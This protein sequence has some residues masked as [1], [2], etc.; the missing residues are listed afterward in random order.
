MCTLD[1]LSGHM[2]FSTVIPRQEMSP[3]V[4]ASHRTTLT[5]TR[6]CKLFPT[7]ITT[8]STENVI[9]LDFTPDLCCNSIA[10]TVT[11]ASGGAKPPPCPPR[12]KI[13]AVTPSQWV[14]QPFRRVPFTTMVTAG[15]GVKVKS[16]KEP[17]YR[18][19]ATLPEEDQAMNLLELSEHKKLLQFHISS[20][21]A[22]RAVASHCNERIGRK[23]GEIL[24]PKQLLHCLK[25]RGMHFTLRA[26]YIDLFNTLHLEPEVRNRLITSGEFIFP[27][28]ACDRSIPLFLPPSEWPASHTSGHHRQ[29][30]S[31]VTTPVEADNALV[32]Q[33]TVGHNMR[34][35]V[36]CGAS[37]GEL[38]RLRFSVKE[39]KQMVF[40]NLEKLLSIK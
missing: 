17:T 31:A 4:S 33:A 34:S 14:R 38:C 3:E 36:P 25:L 20:L 29:R 23:M 15:G 27:L 11:P 37:S 16:Y 26:A 1:L 5:V 12:F 30:P 10:S 8:P 22:Y 39:L 18:I 28:S 13:M 40:Y 2:T 19:Y 35:C 21:K 24:D 7:I 9:D 32:H 6:R